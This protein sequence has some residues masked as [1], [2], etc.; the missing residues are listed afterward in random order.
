VKHI[1]II[2]LGLLLSGCPAEH[3][4]YIHNKSDVT[5]SSSYRTTDWEDVNIRPGRT[6]YVWIRFGMESCL[7]LSIG[8]S[9]IAFHL[10]RTILAESKITRYGARLDAYYEYGQLHFQYKDGR[11]VQLEEVAECKG[12]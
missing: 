2:F 4:I 3:R 10:P 1:V 6:R 5:I 9:A 7:E 8:E 11:W 12:S